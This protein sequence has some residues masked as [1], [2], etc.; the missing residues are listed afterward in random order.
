MPGTV[1]MQDGTELP[2]SRR[3]WNDVSRLLQSNVE[4]ASPDLVSPNELT[5]G[6]RDL[7]M[8]IP[9]TTPPLA[10]LAVM[11]SNSL[12]ITRQCIEAFGLPF[13]LH[14]LEWGVELANALLLNPAQD[15]PAL[16]LLDAR[17]NWPDR[18]LTLRALKSHARLRAIPVVWLTSPG[19]DTMQ[20]YTLQ[21]NSVVVVPNEPESFVQAIEQLCRYWLMLVQLPPERS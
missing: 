2:V 21:A 13:R 11:E 1:E 6:E 19:D 20:A 5:D 18:I 8:G 4:E 14:H 3:R 17:M 16:I 12:R 7:N 10:V 15:R 9:Y